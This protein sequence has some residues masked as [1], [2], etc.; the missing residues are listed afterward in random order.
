MPTEKDITTA[1]L[2]VGGEVCKQIYE[3]ATGQA[4]S[5]L[6]VTNKL[7]MIRAIKK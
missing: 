2:V 4:W 5:D 3:Q 6:P 1:D 7:Q